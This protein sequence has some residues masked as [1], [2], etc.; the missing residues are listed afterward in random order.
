[1]S[2]FRRLAAWCSTLLRKVGVLAVPLAVLAIA[3]PPVDLHAAALRTALIPLAAAALALS[4]IV[5]LLARER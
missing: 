4:A 2:S 3:R 1:M 5:A